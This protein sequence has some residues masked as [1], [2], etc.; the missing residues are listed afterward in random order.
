MATRSQ[1]R[2][3][4]AQRDSRGFVISVRLLR[5]EVP[6]FETFPFS[7]PAVRELDELELHPSVNYFVGENGSG[8]STLI[9]AIAELAGFN[10]EGGSKNFQFSTNRTESELLRYMRL[11]RGMTRER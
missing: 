10:P 4:P 11:S 2:R 3:V 1:R 9:E 8:K 5:D 6:S 7:I